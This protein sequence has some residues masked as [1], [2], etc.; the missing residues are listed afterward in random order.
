MCSV[1]HCWWW[2]GCFLRLKVG[3][4]PRELHAAWLGRDIQALMVNYNCELSEIWPSLLFN[5]LVSLLSNNPIYFQVAMYNS[6]A[7][8]QKRYCWVA[9]GLLLP[10]NLLVMMNSRWTKINYSQKASSFGSNVF[11]AIC[12]VFHLGAEGN[13]GSNV[14]L[15]LSNFYV[16]SKLRLRSAHKPHTPCGRLKAAAVKPFTI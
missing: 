13:I 15:Q 2:H 8:K 4:E 7:T 16:K 5:H 12:F 11:W 10:R 3:I 6:L 9:T 14:P 1:I